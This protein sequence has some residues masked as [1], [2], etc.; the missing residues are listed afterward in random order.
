MAQK[1]LSFSL[2]ALLLSV[3]A[4]DGIRV[5]PNGMGITVQIDPNAPTGPGSVTLDT[6]LY[7]PE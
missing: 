7:T 4:C 5:D 3:F 2:I 6:A 1:F